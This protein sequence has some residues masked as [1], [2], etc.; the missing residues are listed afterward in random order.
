[1]N[2]E[3]TRSETL[4][5]LTNRIRANDVNCDG[6]KERGSIK[7]E[8]EEGEEDQRVFCGAREMLAAE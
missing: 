2:R 5:Q 8:E 6:E 3:I 1:M 7:R 4:D